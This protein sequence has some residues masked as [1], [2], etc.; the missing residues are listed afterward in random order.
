MK[1]S[2]HFFIIFVVF[3]VNNCYAEQ[4]S[5]YQASVPVDSRSSSAFDK[6]VQQALQ[7]VL[8]KV[9]GDTAVN[10][11]QTIQQAFPQAKKFIE[12]YA[13][14]NS[15]G[16]DKKYNLMVSFAPQ[17]VNQLLR[18]TNLPIWKSDR[19]L[20]VAWIVIEQE[21]KNRELLTSDDENNE[22][23]EAIQSTAQQRA[24]PIMLPLADLQ[25]LN[26]VSVDDVWTPMPTSLQKASQRYRSDAILI[27]KIALNSPGK[28]FKW[29]AEWTLLQ[30]GAKMDWKNKADSV[31]QLLVDGVNGLANMLAQ[32]YAEKVV[33]EQ[34]EYLMM[35]IYGVSDL[36]KYTN[37]TNYLT[38]LSSVSALQVEKISDDHVIFKLMIQGGESTLTQALEKDNV[39]TPIDLYNQPQQ[40]SANLNYQLVS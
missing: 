16:T 5:I 19:P 24:I 37:I 34:E 31:Q 38:N 40:L 8:I 9:S 30:Q 4:A 29:R 22:L 13:Y 1:K 26:S 23:I 36:E 17:Q 10:E 6:G 27:G 3:L 14:E 15:T 7:Q 35:A 21:D 28:K 25:S 39:I 2:V 12:K 20:T 33:N 11:N 18:N 32:R